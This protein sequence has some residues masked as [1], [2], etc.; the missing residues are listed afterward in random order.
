MADERLR[1]DMLRDAERL[2]GLLQEGQDGYFTWHMSLHEVMKS[3]VG[4]YYGPAAKVVIQAGPFVMRGYGPGEINVYDCKDC[5]AEGKEH[6]V[7]DQP[8][9]RTGSTSW[10]GP[11]VPQ[12]IRVCSG[13][14][15]SD[16]PW[17]SADYVGSGY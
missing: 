8:F 14:G 17:V 1:K 11:G 4:N 13:C 6:R 5:K 9:E 15:R 12:T 7:V 2:V 10:W 3:L 16:G